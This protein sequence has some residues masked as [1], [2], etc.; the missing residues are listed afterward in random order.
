MTQPL[1][2]AQGPQDSQEHFLLKV[3][4]VLPGAQVLF[5]FQLSIVLTDAFV[6]LPA[7]SRTVRVTLPS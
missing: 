1:A 2:L 7:V 4:D 5:G 3:L 6:Q